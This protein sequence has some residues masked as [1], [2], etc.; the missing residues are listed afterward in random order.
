MKLFGKEK[1]LIKR[2]V[3]GI[4]LVALI[5]SV[6]FTF[7][8][9]VNIALGEDPNDTRYCA[10]KETCSPVNEDC[11][12]VACERSQYDKDME[13]YDETRGLLLSIFSVITFAST[14]FL[15]N[16]KE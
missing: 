8:N 10:V 15:V 3:N 11:N 5:A 16:R 2:S 4:L 7:S 13:V 14:M 1:D 12:T 6:F 9:V